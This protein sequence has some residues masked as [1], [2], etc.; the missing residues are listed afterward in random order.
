MNETHL[1]ADFLILNRISDL[2]SARR[3][4]QEIEQ[5]NLHGS[6]ISPEDL[7]NTMYQIKTNGYFPKILF[8]QGNHNFWPTHQLM[9]GLGRTFK[10]KIINSPTPFFHAR[11]KWATHI[12]WQSHS[13]PVPKTYLL[14][15][16][17][18]TSIMESSTEDLFNEIKD[19]CG[20]PFILKKRFSGQGDD[21]FLIHSTTE[22][23][24]TI[25]KDR[26]EF[27][28]AHDLEILFFKS[29]AKCLKKDQPFCLFLQRWLVQECIHE[30]LGTDVRVF[31]TNKNI[32]AVK[33]K[34]RNSFR[35]NIH[36]GGRAYSTSLSEYEK[37]LCLKAH[38]L[39]QLNYSGIDFLRTKNGPLFLEIN[40]S[41]GFEGIESVYDCN[42]AAEIL[43]ILT[44]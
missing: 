36:K 24:S 34:N 14:S 11:D 27:C 23:N 16:F 39:S 10:V 42:V 32:R 9:L 30:A 12:D 6:L 44:V 20:I 2:Y 18:L 31:V 19:Q 22:F 37:G 38:Q 13:I 29:E 1:D 33:R 41:P 17:Q 28:Q 15:Q 8:R 26:M 25:Q 40:P 5:N 4:K 35:S 21:V 43:N 7:Q 3:F